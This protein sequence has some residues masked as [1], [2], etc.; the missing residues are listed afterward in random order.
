MKASLGKP[1]KVNISLNLYAL[2]GVFSE[3]FKTIAVPAAIAGA[4]LWTTWLRG[5]LNGVIATA[6]S[7]GSLIT[8][9]ST[10][11]YE[12]SLRYNDEI[13]VESSFLAYSDE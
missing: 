7:R 12:L 4:I 8:L 1:Q 13:S 5:W 3:G 10:S 6:K 11:D 2:R 9:S